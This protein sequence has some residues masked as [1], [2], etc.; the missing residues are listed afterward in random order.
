MLFGEK[1]RAAR[2][3]AHLTQEELAGILG[4]TSRSLVN[5]ETGKRIPP[6]EVIAKI[7]KTFQKGV[8]YLYS[9]EDIFVEKAGEQYGAHGR[10]KA[11]QLVADAAG[12]FAGGELDEEDKEAFFKAISDIYF[13][14]KARAKKYTPKKYLLKQPNE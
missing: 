7:S 9:S 8:D 12:L 13:E 2:L 4:I 10:V 5:Y 6:A 1:L 14:S 11:K 3:E